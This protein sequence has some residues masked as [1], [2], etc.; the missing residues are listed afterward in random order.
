MNEGMTKTEKYPGI[1]LE[2]LK[3][4]KQKSALRASIISSLRLK[5]LQHEML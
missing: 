3:K 2:G 5:T 4:I 1:C